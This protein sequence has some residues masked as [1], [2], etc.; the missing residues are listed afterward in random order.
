MCYGAFHGTEKTLTVSPLSDE[1]VSPSAVG[2]AGEICY[3]NGK[4]YHEHGVCEGALSERMKV[5]FLSTV[6]VRAGVN[7]V[8]FRGAAALDQLPA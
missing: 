2:L 1:R 3:A 4:G 6:P 7:P 8:T 5:G